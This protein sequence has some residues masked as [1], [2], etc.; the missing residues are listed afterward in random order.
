MIEENDIRPTK[1]NDLQES[2]VKKD[3]QFLL[4]RKNNFVDIN[5]P[6]CGT[7]NSKVEMQ[8]N[9]FD[10]LECSNCTMLYLSPKL[11][12]TVPFNFKIK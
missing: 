12:G 4:D 8:K 1:Y 11:M 7:I 9:G 2:A 3:I 6:V 10:Y 5:C